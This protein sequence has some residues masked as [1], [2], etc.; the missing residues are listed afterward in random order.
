MVLGK[1]TAESKCERTSYI[2]SARFDFITSVYIEC[3][4]GKCYSKAVIPNGIGFKKLPA[5]YN[6]RFV[7]LK[8]LFF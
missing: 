7:E 6:N 1:H 2:N 8:C 3:A 4:L 5:L